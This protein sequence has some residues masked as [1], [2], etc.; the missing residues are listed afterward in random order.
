MAGEARRRNITHNVFQLEM[1][2]VS[3]TRNHILDVDEADN[4][5][6]ISLGLGIR[7]CGF[8]D[9]SLTR[10]SRGAAISTATISTRGTITLATNRSRV[11]DV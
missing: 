2:S 7:L 4:I 5:V 8:S 1:F 9:R 10:S 11:Q 3:N 6:E